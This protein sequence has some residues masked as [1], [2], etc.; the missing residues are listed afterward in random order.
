M[1]RS[2]LHMCRGEREGTGIC[3]TNWLEIVAFGMSFTPRRRH[4]PGKQWYVCRTDLQ[5]TD[6]EEG[7]RPSQL[8]AITDTTSL[9]SLSP[10]VFWK[11]KF[12]EIMQWNTYIFNQLH[13]KNFGT[14][15]MHIFIDTMCSTTKSHLLSWQSHLGKHIW[16]RSDVAKVLIDFFS[17]VANV[18]SALSF[19]KLFSDVLQGKLH[20]HYRNL[21]FLK[22]YDNDMILWKL[23]LSLGKRRAGR[24]RL[25]KHDNLTSYLST[26]FRDLPWRVLSA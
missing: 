1:F 10:E 13:C 5:M 21:F 24:N 6:Q 23:V 7:N 14:N 11:Y 12:G 17:Y 4:N 22:K 26:V 8:S 19:W 15:L 18:F 2:F 25:D 3:E 9:W 16:T 20:L